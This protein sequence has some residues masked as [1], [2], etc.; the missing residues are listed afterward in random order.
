ME[1]KE[2]LKILREK[3]KDLILNTIYLRQMNERLSLRNI[4]M[5]ELY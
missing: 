4:I 1:M 5:R 2:E 3:L